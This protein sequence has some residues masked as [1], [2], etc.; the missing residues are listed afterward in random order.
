MDYYRAPYLDVNTR[1]P[2]WRWPQEIP[3]AGEPKDVFEALTAYNQKMQD[4]DVPKLHIWVTPGAIGSP[5]NTAWI[6]T[7]L[8]NLKSVN[9][10]EGSQFIQEDHPHRIGR[11]I[12]DWY[13]DL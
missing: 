1:K 2:L 11:K 12:A 10:G 9:V 6:Q 13:Q 8:T 4:W 5:V 7:N 3:I